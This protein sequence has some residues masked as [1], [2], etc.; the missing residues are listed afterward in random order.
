MDELFKR[1]EEDFDESDPEKPPEYHELVIEN[2]FYIYV[3]MQYFLSNKKAKAVLYED[4]EMN[5]V[6]N[7]FGDKGEN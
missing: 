2:G 6:L 4:T 3:L 7:E 5:D 1:A